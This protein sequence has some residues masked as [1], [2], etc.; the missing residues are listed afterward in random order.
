VGHFSTLADKI[1]VGGLLRAGSVFVSYQADLIHSQH[2]FLQFAAGLRETLS[3]L[4]LVAELA[5]F[6]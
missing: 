6:H 3:L 5:Q 4:A 1:P 2:P